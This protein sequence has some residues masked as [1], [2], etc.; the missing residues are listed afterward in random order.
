MRILKMIMGLVLLFL[1]LPALNVAAEDVN[2]QYI[3]TSQGGVT[4][5]A[6]ADEN[7][8]AV[9]KLKK[10]T[11]VNFVRQESKWVKV[12]YNGRLGWVSSEK[13]APFT[14]EL[15][16][17]Y[18][19]YYKLLE[20]T[21]HLV[22]ALL[23]D[24]T[25]DGVEDLY[26]ILDAN[27]EKGQYQEFIYSGDN[28]IYQKNIASGLTVLKSST[29][30][31]LWHHAQTNSDK[32]YKLSELNSQAK[33]DYYEA[34]AGKGS[35][36][37]TT[38]A[39]LNSYFI[40]QSGNGVMNEA[41]LTYEQ[42][43]SKDYSGA[44]NKNDY[45]ESIYLENY[46]LSTGGKTQSLQAKDFDEQFSMYENSKVVK[47]IYEDNYKSAV[48][49]DRFSFDVERVKKEL[50]DLAADAMQANQL[51]SGA[52]DMETLQQKL[53]QSALLEMPY[54]AGI[55]RNAVNYFK[56]VEQAIPKGLVGYDSSTFEMTSDDK[57]TTYNRAAVD[58][59][60]YDFYGLKMNSEAFNRLAN[61]EGY[62]V[63][64]EKYTAGLKEPL[65]D[66]TYMYRQ[67]VA[68]E[69]LE[70]QYVA[71]KFTDYEMPQTVN[72]SPDNEAALI[73]G[74]KHKSGYVL[75]KS[76]PFKSGV[77]WVYI[78][79]VDQLESINDSQYTTYENSLDIIQKLIAEQK[80]TPS[81]FKE[82]VEEEKVENVQQPQQPTQPT[83]QSNTWV[84][85]LAIGILIASSITMYYKKF[86]K[87]G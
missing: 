19:T 76:L 85:F 68:V 81:E 53:A 83:E 12:D 56:I 1:C 64:D 82:P 75:F 74:V 6:S 17:A 22:Y 34:S 54:S 66:E 4:M 39:Y 51:D 36:K 55:S 80:T 20:N 27:P 13:I 40:V 59:L 78:D 16:P 21:D 71:V 30:Y 28:V 10:G 42:I 46:A 23:S 49:S 65:D 63:D 33:T 9:A 48:L 38:N 47:V 43:A 44:D 87:Q 5:T 61:D 70:N 84:I 45:D 79:T 14:K 3:V 35:Y 37:I 25:Q 86:Y 29:D 69:S 11:R 52:A 62:M 26:V 31:I 57:E 15:L 32:K 77:K 60:I 58:A 2:Q 67:L 18:S 41:T 24:F 72:I 7:G 50:L 73:A 8:M